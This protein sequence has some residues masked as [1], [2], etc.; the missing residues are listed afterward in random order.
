MHIL[1]KG[2]IFDVAKRPYLIHTTGYNIKFLKL[3]N[4]TTSIFSIMSTLR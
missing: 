4:E 2:L 3:Q 1:F